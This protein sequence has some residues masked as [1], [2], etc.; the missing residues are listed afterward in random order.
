MI[1]LTDVSKTFGETVAVDNLSLRVEPGEIFGFLG[2]NGAGKTTTIKMMTGLYRPTKGRLVIGGYDIA[3]EPLKAKALI[4]YIPDEPFVYEQL[5]G[6]EFLSFIGA[7][8]GIPEPE[9]RRRIEKL[10][11]IFPIAEVVDGYFGDFSRGTKQKITILAALLHE[12]RVLIID[13]PMVGLD[14]QSVR[15]VKDLLRDFVAGGERA[16]LMSTHSL[17]IAESVCG[18]I[19]II[20]RG[21]LQ[22]EGTLDELR[23][24]AQM[25]QGSLEEL[26]LK[27]CPD[28]AETL[29][30]G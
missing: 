8:Y 21:R 7:V 16:V 20:N 28:G 17:N 26:F 23:H 2:P 25:D 22:Q 15:I 12:P 18:R 5:T 11:R 24:K 3:V 4:G 13:E 10:L 19:A 14:P 27:I 1:E 30:A 9:R 6:V 29:M